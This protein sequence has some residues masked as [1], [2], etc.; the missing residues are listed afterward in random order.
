MGESDRPEG[1]DAPHFRDKAEFVVWAARTGHGGKGRVIGDR[2]LI[3]ILTSQC[4]TDDELYEVAYIY[5]PAM[6]WGVE[7]FVEQARRIGRSG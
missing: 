7:E 3:G 2:E 5:A 4:Y 1:P 6:G